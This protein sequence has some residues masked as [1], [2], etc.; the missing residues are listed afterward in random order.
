MVTT[1]IGRGLL[2]EPPEWVHQV[3]ATDSPGLGVEP[4]LDVLGE[5]ITIYS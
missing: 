5:A 2:R 1:Q 4:I 3:Y